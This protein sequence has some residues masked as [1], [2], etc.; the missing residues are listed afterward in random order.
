MIFHAAIVEEEQCR[1]IFVHLHEAEQDP[2]LKIKFHGNVAVEV[3][4]VEVV[5]AERDEEGAT[6]GRGYVVR[7]HGGELVVDV[8]MWEGRGLPAP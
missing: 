8:G 7:G 4:G 5:I 3:V 1:G 2:E 6:G